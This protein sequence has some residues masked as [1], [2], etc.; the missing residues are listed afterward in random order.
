MF[1]IFGGTCSSFSSYRNDLII[2]Q[3]SPS[4]YFTA[5]DSFNDVLN[6]PLLPSSSKKANSDNNSRPTSENK[7]TRDIYQTPEESFN[8]ESQNNKNLIRTEELK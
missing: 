4:S 1:L 6:N 3:G 5:A 7:S 2:G 8:D